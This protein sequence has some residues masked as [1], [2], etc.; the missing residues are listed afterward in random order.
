MSK[1]N[2]LNKI[3][4]TGSNGLIG[5]LLCKNL[6]G[7]YAVWGFD[8]SFSKTKRIQSKDL[9][10]YSLPE[11]RRIQGNLGNLKEV[12]NA[13]RGKD[14]VIHLAAN[15]SPVA[16]WSEI[17]KNNIEGTFN[18]FEAARLASIKRVIFASSNHAVGM[19]P[20]KIDPYKH[21][22]HENLEKIKHPIEPLTTEAVRPANLYGVSKAFGESLGS[23]YYDK[24]ELSVIC[25]RIGWVMDPD[26]PTFSAAGLALWLS[27]RDCVQLFGKAIDA[28]MGLEFFVLY[29][30]SD[31]KLLIWDL[32]KTKKILK[33]KPRDGAGI[34]WVPDDSRPGIFDD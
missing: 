27:H 31:N 29:G 8:R 21:I 22:Y 23:Y 11:D 5:T 18:V 13:M 9:K 25:L 32:D 28:S 17:L 14:C 7:N 19:Y 12:V 16:S 6:E 10:E 24:Y 3:L 30:M 26:D 15:P 20:E 33:Y 34:K 1:P 2:S 4:I